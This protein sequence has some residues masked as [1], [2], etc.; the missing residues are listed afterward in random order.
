M[1]DKHLKNIDS[2]SITWIEQWY[3]AFIR[4]KF[5]LND[6]QILRTDRSGLKHY[7]KVNVTGIIENDRL[8]RLWGIQ[9]DNTD[10]VYAE[11]ALR[12]S[13]EHFRALAENSPEII[14]RFDSSFRHLYVNKVIEKYTGKAPAFFMYKSFRQ[15]GFP[16]EFIEKSEAA[17]NFV[18][19]HKTAN[20]VELQLQSGIW[21]D[22]LLFPEFDSQYQVKGVVSSARDISEIKNSEVELRSAKNK[23]EESDRLKSAFLANMSHEIRTP[24]NAILGYSE[25]LEDS[26]LSTEERSGFLK[27]LRK[28]TNDL[29]NLINDILDISQIEANQLKL[30]RHPASLRQ[31]IQEMQD[32]FS[33]MGLTEKKNI[34]FEIQDELP[35]EIDQ[36]IIDDKRIKQILVNLLNNAYKFTN[37]GKITL[38]LGLVDSSRLEF[39]IRDTGRGI[40]ADR[41]EHIFDRFRQGEDE[42]FSKKFG[43]NGL[44]LTIVK[45]LVEN[46]GGKIYVE[47]EIEKG[48]RFSFVIPF[49]R[50][51]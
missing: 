4:N 20:R 37:E 44:G 15:L 38:K 46:M 24:M 17:I 41:L 27:K 45:G 10:T 1:I 36:I 18:F 40:A 25:L 26:D 31:L 48:T 30:F 42:S 5:R 7:Y 21:I 14:S 32:V 49:E 6:F 39:S 2:V 23:A 33:A 47:S 43:G 35:N 12:E 50:N 29:L 11:T 51:V 13:E 19:Q 34:V 8:V 22:W 16:E 9:N 28:R 3:T